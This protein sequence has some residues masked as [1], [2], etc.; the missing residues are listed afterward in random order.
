MRGADEGISSKCKLT[1]FS[2]CIRYYR[3]LIHI[4]GGLYK[5]MRARCHAA[6]STSVLDTA[7]VSAYLE[8]A[9][10][11]MS[12]SVAAVMPLSSQAWIHFF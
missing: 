1:K 2:R 4:E 9:T 10:T 11:D 3:G 8:F 12:I 7:V 5:T 6:S